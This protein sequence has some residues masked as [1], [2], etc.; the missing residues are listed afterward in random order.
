MVRLAPS[1]LAA[2]FAA[3]GEAI[4]AAE[5]GGADLIHVDVMD[6]HLATKADHGPAA[7]STTGVSME[8]WDVSTPRTFPPTTPIPVISMPV[9]SCAPY[10]FAALTYPLTT[11]FGST[12]PSSG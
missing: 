8:P 2:D 11:L 5:R 3:L 7:S 12:S 1:I 4:A 10:R 6:G 9:N